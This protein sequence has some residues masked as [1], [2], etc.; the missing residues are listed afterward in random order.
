MPLVSDKATTRLQRS[1][2]RR[3]RSE[4][5][6]EHGALSQSGPHRNGHIG[7]QL[8]RHHPSSAAG[9]GVITVL[10]ICRMYAG[11]GH[12]TRSTSENDVVIKKCNLIEI[13]FF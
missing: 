1:P 2:A 10:R 4:L 13:K 9:N 12:T 6:F 7:Q 3:S 8:V 11:R 5:G